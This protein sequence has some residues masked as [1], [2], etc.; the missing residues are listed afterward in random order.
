MHIIPLQGIYIAKMHKI[1]SLWA[2]RPIS[3]S[4]G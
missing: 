2:P 3:A 1:F 4:M